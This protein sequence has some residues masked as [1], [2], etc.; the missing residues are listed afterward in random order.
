MVGERPGQGLHNDNN[1]PLHQPPLGKR[2]QMLLESCTVLLHILDFAIKYNCG[3]ETRIDYF[4][5]LISEHAQIYTS[6]RLVVS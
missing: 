1:V 5:T 3:R 2:K 4:V 6:R